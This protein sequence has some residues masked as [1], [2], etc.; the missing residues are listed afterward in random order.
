[1]FYIIADEF[2]CDW[3]CATPLK[4][5]EREW[6]Q[7]KWI[8][9]SSTFFII[10]GAYYLYA[11]TPTTSIFPYML[12]VTSLVS[13]NYWRNATRGWRRNLDL[14]VAKTTFSTGVYIS[15]K[16]VQSWSHL[17]P[18]VTLLCILPFLYNGSTKCV[19]TDNP[20]WIKYHFAFHALCSIIG[21]FILR[22]SI[23]N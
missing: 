23:N 8:V 14:I 6:D 16:Y 20:A 11:Y 10:P 1:M 7:T 21:A 2:G 19:N 22:G 9:V 5:I 4:K 3:L 12:I 13:A 15:A 17:I 18:I